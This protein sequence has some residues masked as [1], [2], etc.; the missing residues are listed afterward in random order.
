MTFCGSGSEDENVVWRELVCGDKK[1]EKGGGTL[2]YNAYRH[3]ETAQSPYSWPANEIDK[4]S[5]R[6]HSDEQ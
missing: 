5:S 1:F 3:I 4:S 6:H 2:S